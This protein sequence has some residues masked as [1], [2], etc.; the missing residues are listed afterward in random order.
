MDCTLSSLSDD[1]NSSDARVNPEIK[2]NL[3][4]LYLDV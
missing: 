1:V 4:L 3:L 2:A